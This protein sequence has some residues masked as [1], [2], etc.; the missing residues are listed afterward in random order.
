MAKQMWVVRLT[1]KPPFFWAW[2]VDY[3]PRKFYYKKDAL[4][5]LAQVEKSGCTAVVEKEQSIN[6]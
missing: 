6:K 4:D 2:E 5:L 3:F 1:Q